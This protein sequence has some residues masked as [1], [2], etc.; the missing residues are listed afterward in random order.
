MFNHEE[1]ELLSVKFSSEEMTCDRLRV[2]LLLVKYE[3]LPHS[4]SYDRHTY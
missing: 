4:P 2:M 1:Y 3:V